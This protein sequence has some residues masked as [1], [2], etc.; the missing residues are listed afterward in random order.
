MLNTKLQKKKKLI[1]AMN[2]TENLKFLPQIDFF[3]K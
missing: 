1:K 2:N 3:L